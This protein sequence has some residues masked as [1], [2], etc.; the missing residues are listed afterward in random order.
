M[1]NIGVAIHS[2]LK[3]VIIGLP[4][5]SWTITSLPILSIL[6]ILTFIVYSP[7]IFR[8]G[9]LTSTDFVWIKRRNYLTGQEESFNLSTLEA[10]KGEER[11][12]K[13]MKLRYYIQV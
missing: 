10:I 2:L 12:L 1:N 7:N 3:P 4:N 9:G 8:N 11:A 13:S 6:S 5:K